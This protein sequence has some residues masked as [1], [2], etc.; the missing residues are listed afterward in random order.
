MRL[1]LSAVLLAAVPALAN[2]AAPA[3]VDLKPFL[4]K[5]VF[6]AITLSPTGEYLAAT[7]PLEDRTGVVVMRYPAMEVTARVQLEKDNH[8]L[9]MTWVN[10]ERLVMG[11]AEKDGDR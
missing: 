6:N 1:L 2:A 11:V 5:D 4:Q 9:G 3:P 7:V 8:V 10:D